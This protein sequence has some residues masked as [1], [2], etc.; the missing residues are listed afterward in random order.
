MLNHQHGGTRTSI[1]PLN[2]LSLGCVTSP[3][4]QSDVF[5][6]VIRVRLNNAATSRIKVNPAVIPIL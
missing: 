5:T 6:D 1:I 2:R 4:T 3:R